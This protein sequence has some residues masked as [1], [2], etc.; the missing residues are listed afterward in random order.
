MKSPR[1]LSCFINS[2]LLAANLFN[3]SCFSRTESYFPSVRLKS[4][5]NLNAVSDFCSASLTFASEVSLV[6]KGASSVEIEASF[7]RYSSTV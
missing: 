7:A 2:G 5:F 1:P 6:V 4:S 3:A